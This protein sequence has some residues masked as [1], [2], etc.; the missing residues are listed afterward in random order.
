MTDEPDWITKRDAAILAGVD[1]RTIERKARAGRINAKARPGFPTLY[2]RA[3]V[4]KLA[5]TSR[6]EVRTGFLEE[7]APAS[8]NGHGALAHQRTRIATFEEVLLDVIQALR[9]AL[10]QGSIGPTGP[11][12][13]A[14]G[15]TDGGPTGPTAK[16]V[17]RAEALAIAGVSD[18]Q[19]RKAVKAG[20]VKVRGRRY[21]RKD[22]EAL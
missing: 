9:G 8:S 10:A 13:A 3:E 7:V 11:T 6:Q 16:Y 17:D 14:T 5:Q 4:E 12:G 21:R 2:L 15:P 22:V 19:L 18:D 20:E 1:E